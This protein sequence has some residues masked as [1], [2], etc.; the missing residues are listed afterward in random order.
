MLYHGMKKM[1][2]HLHQIMLNLLVM[3]VALF[4]STHWFRRMDLKQL[5][6]AVSHL[7]SNLI[8]EV[9]T[10]TMLLWISCQIMGIVWPLK[11]PCES[12]TQNLISMAKNAIMYMH[13]QNFRLAT[14]NFETIS[15]SIIGHGIVFQLHRF[16]VIALWSK[17]L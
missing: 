14:I 8:K 4:T 2:L 10:W 17:L 15:S 9:L 16:H 6:Q 7:P 11:I 13:G 3:E 5:L 12:C 1:S